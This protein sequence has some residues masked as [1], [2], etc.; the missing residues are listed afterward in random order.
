MGVLSSIPPEYVL[1][2]GFFLIV[3]LLVGYMIATR[4]KP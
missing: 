4:R 1:I 2:A 3:G